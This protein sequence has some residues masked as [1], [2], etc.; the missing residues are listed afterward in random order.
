MTDM[1]EKLGVSDK[2]QIIPLF[3]FGLFCIT[4]NQ[5]PFEYILKEAVI[6]YTT[7]HCIPFIY[8]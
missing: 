8:I 3:S 5:I 1:F 7:K 2:K 4:E 6:M